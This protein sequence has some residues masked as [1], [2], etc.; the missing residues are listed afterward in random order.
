ML[1]QDP[2]A[3]IGVIVPDLTRLRGEGGADLS[4]DAGP[5]FE[6]STISERSF[7]VSLGPALDRVS[8]GARGAADAGIRRPARCRCRGPEC[9]CVLRSL[10]ARKQNGRK[11]AQLDAK[12]RRD[13]VWDIIAGPAARPR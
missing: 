8:G 11:R 4:R 10:A 2:E 12:L 6:R 7:H 3:Q 5:G 1:E 9:C 13:G